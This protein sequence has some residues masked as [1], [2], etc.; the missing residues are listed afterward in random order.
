MHGP[1]GLVFHRR[2]DQQPAVRSSEVALGLFA[3][4]PGP[5]AG[6]LDGL[7]GLANLQLTV[8]QLFGV[9]RGEPA[10]WRGV[11]QNGGQWGWDLT[12]IRLSPYAGL[13]NEQD[14]LRRLD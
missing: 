5:G 10:T 13:Q 8:E 3:A 9:L 4:G 7:Q 14:Y 2:P 12:D 6:V 11:N 1:A